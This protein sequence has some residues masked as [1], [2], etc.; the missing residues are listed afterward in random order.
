MPPIVA[1]IVFAIG[2]FGL[3][4]LDRDRNYR[5]SKALWIPA[6][7]LFLLSS[8]PVS[9]WLGMTPAMDRAEAYIEGSP[10]DRAVFMALL[11]AGLGVLVGRAE[12]VGPLLR[13]NAPIVL[14]FSYCAVSVAWSDFP[15]VAFKRWTKALGDVAMILVILT[16]P[17]PMRA[18]RWLMTRLGYVL[19]PLSVLFI[20]Y[21]PNLGRRLTNSWTLEPVGIGT[22]KNGLGMICLV[23]GLGFL[24]YLLAAHRDRQDPSRSGRMVAFG[25]ILVVI[26]WLLW[27]CDSKSAI[28][29]LGMAGG[30]MLLASRPS[31]AC[32]RSV[33]HL[34]VLTAL[35]V[36]VYSVFFDSAG[37]LVQG[38]GRDPSL[39]GRTAVW[40]LVL[41]TRT[42]PWV[43]TG[44]ESF[45]LGQRLDEMRNALPNLD[46][47][48]A[49]NGYLEVYA[50]L[51]WTGVSLLALLLVTGYRKII[52]KFRQDP[53]TGSLFLAYLL[54]TVCC[55]FSESAFRMLSTSWFFLLL[56]VLA[57]SLAASREEVRQTDAGQADDSGD[58]PAAV[59]YQAHERE[60]ARAT[61]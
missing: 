42:N 3:L 47:N 33:V 36:S 39:T 7:W 28:C 26:A 12:R 10:I 46:I 48:E 57:A 40:N 17:K 50:N 27:V 45:W 35:S 29:S 11:V 22:Q 43:G 9:T 18:L 41:S 19:F 56:A 5:P 58:R 24:S 52:A 23:Y 60:K 34:L 31:L 51:G 4:Y 1:T 6:A 32:K 20:R 16:D 59:L 8:R 13:R 38:L 15:F 55:S 25:T 53:G 21:Y 49:H 61:W 54:A 37:S 30:I 2:I 44:F 14:F